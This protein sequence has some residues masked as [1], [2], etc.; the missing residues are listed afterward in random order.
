MKIYIELRCRP[1]KSFGP[2]VLTLEESC[3]EYALF[4]I[5]YGENLT[6]YLCLF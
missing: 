1:F 3:R 4:L 6:Q 2:P 5:I